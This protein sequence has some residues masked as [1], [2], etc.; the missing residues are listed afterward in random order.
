MLKFGADPKGFL[1][2]ISIDS[3]L[4]VGAFCSIKIASWISFNT[5]EIDGLSIPLGFTHINA[6]SVIFHTDSIS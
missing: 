5:S 2:N 4:L 6:T 1:A 3:T